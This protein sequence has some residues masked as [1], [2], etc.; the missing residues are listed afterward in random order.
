VSA[1]GT[2]VRQAASGVYQV[3][4]PLPMRPSIVNVWLI[5]GDG[6]WALVDTGMRTDE[7]LAALREALAILE[8]EPKAVRKIICTHH[9][10][11][12]F[13]SS[14]PLRELWGAEVFIHELEVERT[15]TFLPQ[16]RS[17]AAAS[18]F[19]RHGI[20]LERFMHVPTPG[21]F[22]AGMYVPASPDH[23]LNDG[24]EIPIGK[25]TVRVVWTPGHAPGHC[26][27]LLPDLRALIVGD[28]LLPRI[29]PHVGVYPT[30]PTNPLGDYLESL[31][32][33]AR[34]DVELVLPAHGGIYTD[35]RH[36]VRQLTQHHEYR[37]LAAI[38][39]VR[40]RAQTAYD[41]ARELFDFA[42]DAPVQVQFPATFE[43]LAHLE[44]LVRQ[45]HLTR[46][47]GEDRVLF[48][49]V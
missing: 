2:R 7:S 48:R 26:C 25:R 5:D 9:H 37:M 22:W 17:A 39:T 28:H 3:F 36:R 1:A 8:I 23:F 33:V 34:L 18:F 38:D 6:E 44:V 12:H 29:S 45:G 32:K 35:H 47:E 27:I 14:G 41:I 31:Q 42:G 40:T 15:Q 16:P 46:T 19:R 24:D 10:P 13:G 11:D 49:A 20:P 43:A 30:G 21:E 4:L